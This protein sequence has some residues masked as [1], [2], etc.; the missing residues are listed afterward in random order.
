MCC[1]SDYIFLFEIQALSIN[2]LTLLLGLGLFTNNHSGEDAQSSSEGLGTFITV[3]I[4]FSNGLFLLSVAYTMVKYSEV[5]AVCKSKKRTVKRTATSLTVV[6]VPTSSSGSGS[7]SESGSGN[8]ENDNASSSEKKKEEEQLCRKKILDKIENNS[9]KTRKLS[10]SGLAFVNKVVTSDQAHRTQLRHTQSKARATLQINKKK[11]VASQK[12]NNRLLSRK[13]MK[14]KDAQAT[15]IA[16]TAPTEQVSK[17]KR[18]SVET[19][20]KNKETSVVVPG[21]PK[22]LAES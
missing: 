9:D 13:R 11:N 20:S 1:F 16:A 14:K 17:N 22:E 10:T 18:T 7:G 2:V 19:V 12:L 5:C 6:V 8:D 21:V 3:C 15:S 4:L